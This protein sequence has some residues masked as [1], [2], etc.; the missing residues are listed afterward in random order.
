V[1]LEKK[2]LKNAEGGAEC[3]KNIT[4]GFSAPLETT[5]GHDVTEL[6]YFRNGINFMAPQTDLP[7]VWDSYQNV[8]KNLR[9]KGLTEGITITSYYEDRQGER[10]ET[11]WTINP[12]L[13]EGSGYSEYKGYEDEVQA[14]ED[15]ARALEKISR[16]LKEVKEAMDHSRE[17]QMG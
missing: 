13:L 15:Q 1:G 7:A 9:D 2:I 6:P 3:G 16:D 17:E 12:L 11:S 14:L 8:V 4:F 5:S 10:Y